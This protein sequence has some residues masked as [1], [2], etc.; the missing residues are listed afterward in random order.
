MNDSQRVKGKAIDIDYTATRAFFEARG[1][2]EFDNVLSATMYQDRNAELVIQRDQA[3]KAAVADLLGL[4]DTRRVLDI[5]CGT[6]RWSWFLAKHCS[7]LEYLGIDFSSS[8]IDKARAEADRR[9]LSGMQFQVMSATDIHSEELAILA[10]FDLTLVSGLLIYLND[11]DVLKVLRDAARLSA[12]GG[13]IYVREPVGVAERFTL[14]GFYSE[15][16]ADN[17]SAIYRTVDELK[18]L[19]NHAFM[20]FDMRIEH[21]RFLFEDGLERRTETRQY[22]FV[23]QRQSG[24]R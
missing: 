8:L 6:G 13:R 2:R 20:E 17:Y 11:G 18:R 10:P 23:L 24:D 15:E 7:G 21:E 12:A 1:K 22:C 5:G 3:E 4:G 19:M 16:L 9:R 14:D